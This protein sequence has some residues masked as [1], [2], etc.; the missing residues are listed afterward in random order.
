MIKI[1]IKLKLIFVNIFTLLNIFIKNLFTSLS[2]NVHL[3]A[4]VKNQYHPSFML[5]LC[6]PIFK[7]ES[8]EL[9]NIVKSSSATTSIADNAILIHEYLHNHKLENKR[10][11]EITCLQLVRNNAS[12]C[13]NLLHSCRLKGRA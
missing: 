1:L 6:L 3:V 10:K 4:S 2:S 11:Q 12:L 5:H 7:F 8:H 9:F 13:K